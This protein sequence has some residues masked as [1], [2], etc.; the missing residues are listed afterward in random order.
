MGTH[1][2]KFAA[3]ALTTAYVTAHFF[4]TVADPTRHSSLLLQVKPASSTV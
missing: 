1:G 2:Q 4:V 3:A